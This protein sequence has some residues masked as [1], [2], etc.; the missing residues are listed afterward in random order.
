[1][2]GTAASLPRPRSLG[3][4]ILA[5]RPKTLLVSIVPVVVGA[6]VAYQAGAVRIGPVLAALAG[7]LLIQIG[8]NLAND[9]FDF[10]KGAD[11]GDR[12]G[13]PR[14]AQAGLLS[15][16][17]LRA[18]MALTFGLAVVTGAYLTWVG[19]WI[20]VAIGLASIASGLAYTG[21]P[22]PL[23]YN[24]LGDLFVLAFFGPVAVMGTT[25]V[26]SGAAGPL[27]FWASLPVGA[28]AAAVLVVNNVRD[29]RGDVR[30]GKRTL[31]VRWGRSFGVAEY[32]A[33]LAAS[34]LAPAALVASGLA[35]PWVMITWLT[36]PLAATL[37][38]TVRTERGGEPLNRC[39]A[40]TARLLFVHGVLLAI[41]LVV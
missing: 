35:S 11:D 39:L 32:G 3:A 31:V 26:A 21:G 14:A 5:S 16:A 38:R 1:M 34:Y 2:K 24:G 19:G 36:L 22:Y 33:L 28:L 17:E 10:E 7:A 6:A 4:W 9:V 12:I 29:H 41:G 8:T 37:F 15:P 40:G 25:F 20:I 23:G 18:G 30:A 27:A 13:P